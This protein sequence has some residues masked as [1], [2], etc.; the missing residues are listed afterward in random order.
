MA[1]WR[2]GKEGG[3][4]IGEGLRGGNRRCESGPG[5]SGRKRDKGARLTI[6][7]SAH[8]ALYHSSVDTSVVRSSWCSAVQQHCVASFR[9]EQLELV[10]QLVLQCFA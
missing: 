1:E 5:E 8:L 3:R 6:R 7:R 2:K 9:A 4:G 10:I